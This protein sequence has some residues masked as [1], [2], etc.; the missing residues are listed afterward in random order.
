MGKKEKMMKRVLLLIVLVL[1]VSLVTYGLSKAKATHKKI[2]MGMSVDEVTSIL[3]K[4]G[5]RHMYC[6]E[7]EHPKEGWEK[8]T[9]L[10]AESFRELMDKTT[11]RNNEYTIFEAG[12][13]VVFKGPGF[14]NN[15]FEILF[16]D[17]GKVKSI[18]DLKRWD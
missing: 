2:K 4:S 17:T 9:T 10:L 7:F 1:I 11:N 13:I 3:A 16:D 15:S 14:L 12:I 6:L 8:H 5:G 18:S